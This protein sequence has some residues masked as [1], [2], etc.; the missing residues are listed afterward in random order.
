DAVVVAAAS[1][2]RAGLDVDADARLGV[3]ARVRSP[4]LGHAAFA[5]AV[6]ARAVLVVKEVAHADDRGASEERGR[7]EGNEAGTHQ[8]TP[9][10]KRPPPA[11]PACGTTRAPVVRS[12]G[13]VKT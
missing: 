12:F 1:V 8:N 7:C 2:L 11:G 6:A 4:A 5:A 9:V 13:A 3:G 10:T